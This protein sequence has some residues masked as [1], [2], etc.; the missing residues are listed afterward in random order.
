MKSQRVMTTISMLQETHIA[1]LMRL[2]LQG[3]QLTYEKTF[4]T[5]HF[6]FVNWNE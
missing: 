2:Q 3:K 1:L 4:F 5:N 6:G